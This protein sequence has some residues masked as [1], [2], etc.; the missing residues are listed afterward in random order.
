[1]CETL[2][3]LGLC[4]ELVAWSASRTSLADV[5]S[6]CPRGDWLL[7][8]AVRARVPRRSVVLA[9]LDCARTAQRFVPAG[10]LRPGLAIA[11]AVRWTEGLA[12]GAECWAAA[13]QASGAAAEAVDCEAASDAANAV[14]CTAFACDNDADD[15]YYADRAYAAEAALLAARAFRRTPVDAH[16]VCAELVRRRIPFDE[17]ASRIEHALRASLPPPPPDRGVLGSE[18]TPRP[19]YDPEYV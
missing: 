1:M 15:A 12:S 17:V 7:A 10:D 14:A 4:A 11:T 8:L 19:W 9:A 16:F 2:E 6:D 5:W 13:F 3:Q 18:L